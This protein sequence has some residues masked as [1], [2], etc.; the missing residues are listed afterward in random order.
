M[1]SAS[2]LPS[3]KQADGTGTIVSP[4]E[5]RVSVVTEPTG[6]PSV[7]ATLLVKRA[8]SST[9]AWPNTRCFG[10]PEASWVSAVIS[11]SG[12]DTTMITAS[13]ECAAM[14]SATPRTILALTSSRSMRLMPGLRGRPAVI[15]TTSEPAVAS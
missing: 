11:S 8:V 1:T 13:G 5:P 10:K 2:G 4:C 12:F 6:T 15:T 7:V 14:F 9:P 3:T